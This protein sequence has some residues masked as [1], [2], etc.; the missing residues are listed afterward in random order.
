MTL[1]ATPPITLGQV[2]AE[3]GAPAGSPLGFF[4]RGGPYVPN[5]AQNA[6]VPTA[7]PI[8]MGQLCGASATT[9]INVTQPDVTGS[10]SVGTGNAIIGSASASASGGTPPYTYNISYVSGAAFTISTPTSPTT[11]F[12]RLANPPAGTVSGVYS[13]VATDAA[14]ATGS[15]SFTVTDNRM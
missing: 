1:P 8:S 9:T 4:L 14:G 15:K 13:V 12:R 3:F 6:N 11:A 5:T 2:Y 7:L 10:T